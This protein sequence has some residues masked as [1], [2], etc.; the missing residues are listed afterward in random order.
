MKD[1]IFVVYS[2]S[3]HSLARAVFVFAEVC[4]V[5]RV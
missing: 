2:R 4:V 3:S 1:N 5:A